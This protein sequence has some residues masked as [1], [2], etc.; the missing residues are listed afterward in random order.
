MRVC[1]TL[2]NWDVSILHGRF[3][4]QIHLIDMVACTLFKHK[5]QSTKMYRFSM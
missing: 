1:L 2:C 4:L 3:I 5:L